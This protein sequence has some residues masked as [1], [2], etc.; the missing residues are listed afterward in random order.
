[1]RSEAYAAL[2]G[3]RD[4]FRSLVGRWTAENPY[5]PDLQERLRLELGYGDYRV[6]TPVVYNRALDDI[7]PRD[8]PPRFVLVADNP[9]K[10]EQLTRNNRYLVGQSGKLAEGWFSR[11]LGLDFRREALLLNKTPVHTPKT[12]ELRRL[13][14]LAGDDRPRLEALL[15][16]SQ[17]AMAGLAFRAAR[18][19]GAAIWISGVGELRGG[20]LFQAYRDAL[21]ELVSSAP[22]RSRPRVLAFNHFSMNQ[23][24]I[25]LARKA[26]PTRPLKEELER[27]GAENAARVLGL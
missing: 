24:S 16:E 27:I 23:F 19:L 21:A 6:E 9:G 5:L 12:A 3:L 13:L 22:A 7:G 11:E 4:E 10:N 2:S 1:M 25:E 15:G 14:A 8:R 17:R 18:A 26:D 20:G